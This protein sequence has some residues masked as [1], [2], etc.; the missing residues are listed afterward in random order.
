MTTVT[1]AAIAQALADAGYL[2]NADLDA[3]A[4]ILADALVVEEA[5]AIESTAL[6]DKAEQE[7][8]ILDAEFL[9][10]TA[11]AAADFE[12][13]AAAQD[14][15]DDAFVAVVEDK[16]I[17]DEAETVIEAAYSD[18][19]AALLAAELID[20]A[21]LEAAAGLIAEVWTEYDE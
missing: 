10:D 18:A 16:A 2:S 8:T 21:N 11:V 9:A 19:A 15:I 6:V 4:D 3:A 20:E 5:E 1:T 17:I 14:V 13:E 12:T 7:E